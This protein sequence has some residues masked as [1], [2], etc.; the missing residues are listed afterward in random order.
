ML[1]IDNIKI[2]GTMNNEPQLQQSILNVNDNVPNVPIVST[3]KFVRKRKTPAK[4]VITVTDRESA[5]NNLIEKI[6]EV[7]EDTGKPKYTHKENVS[8]IVDF[9]KENYIEEKKAVKY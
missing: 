4:K 2:V 5:L 1:N 9:I 3:K 7:D 8:N 6:K